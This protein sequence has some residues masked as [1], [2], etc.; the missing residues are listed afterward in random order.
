LWEAIPNNCYERR[1]KTVVVG[2]DAKQS[3][4]GRCKPF[5]WEVMQ[6]R[7]VSSDVTCSFLG[8]EGAANLL[9]QQS[10]CETFKIF[11]LVSG[12]PSLVL[13]TSGT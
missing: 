11:L 5:L 2:D 8:I 4:W 3:L 12:E 13:N 7:V 1:C 10:C 6:N 9:V